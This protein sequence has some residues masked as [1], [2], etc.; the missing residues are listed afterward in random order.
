MFPY[1]FYSLCVRK[2]RLI[3]SLMTY[4][5]KYITYSHF[6]IPTQ[7]SRTLLFQINFIRADFEAEDLREH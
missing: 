3:L 2:K 1:S 6:S 5:P 4:R 7:E